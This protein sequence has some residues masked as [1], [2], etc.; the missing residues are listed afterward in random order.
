MGGR[1]G[2]GVGT[3]GRAP[4]SG[5]PAA[6]ANGGRNPATTDAGEP[7]WPLAANTAETTAIANADPNRCR[8]FSTPDALPM[9][10]GA[11]ELMAALGVLGSAIEIPTPA[12]TNGKTR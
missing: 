3:G 12:M 6:T 7:K 1:G 4:R 8:V 10:A 11:T 9:S 5:G 2:V